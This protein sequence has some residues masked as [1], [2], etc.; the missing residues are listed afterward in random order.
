MARYAEDKRLVNR[1]LQGD[2]QAFEDIYETYLPR[3][4]RF[5]LSRVNVSE[6]DAEDIVQRTFLN[7]FRGM[8]TFRGDSAL[9]TWL[10]TICRHEIYDFLKK[11]QRNANDL[12]F[13]EDDQVVRQALEALMDPA[14]W[15]PE[16]L[17]MT[18]DLVRL[19]HST[20]DFLPGNYG[21]V[22]ERRYLLGESVTEIA[23]SL[24]LG[25]EAADSLLSRA[26]RA[27]RTGFSEVLSAAQAAGHPESS[28][29]NEAV[30][31]R[32]T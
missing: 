6:S 9:F 18:R 2:E 30:P 13:V 12:Q 11:N 21:D 20:L 26:R 29:S 10:C 5:V 8:R 4:Y 27:F 16:A 17:G 3:V 15:D 32:V 28:S 19:V 23:A 7:A 31:G 14:R 22:L 24:G 25:R 1:L